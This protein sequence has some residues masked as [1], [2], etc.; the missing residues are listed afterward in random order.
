MG[1]AFVI[2]TDVYKYWQVDFQKGTIKIV[3]QNGQILEDEL[4]SKFS[5]RNSQ[6]ADSTFDWEKWW[7]ISTTT[8]GHLI[9]TEGFNPNSPPPFNGRPSVYL[10]QNRWRTV[11]DALH[12]P[13]RIADPGE[14]Q[15]AQDLIQLALDGGIVLPLSMGHMLETAG[16]HN[17]RRYEVGV[18]MGS[19]A[20]GWQIRNPLDLWK[21]EAELTIRDHLG[22]PEVGHIYP[23]VTEPGAL[24]GSDTRLG[25][26]NE[27]TD[28]DTFM[29]M[30]TMPN[31]ILSSLIDPETMPKHPL[32]MWIDHHARIT[33]RM[34]AENV[35]KSQRRQLARRRYWNENI[36][37]Y[38]APYR[39]L[40]RSF[41]FPTFSDREVA[42]LLSASPMVGLLSEL[43]VRRFTDRQNKWRRNDLI[44]I[45]HLSSAAAYA[46]YVCA[47][48]HTGTQLREAQRAL[49]RSET[50][51]TS[52]GAL[53]TAVRRDG[54]KTQ[55]ERLADFTS[56]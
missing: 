41:D 17:E 5:P 46:N 44:D 8:R 53:V 6:I 50:V 32:T 3:C 2:S 51:F 42:G 38:T 29:A 28:V 9:I 7:I 16:L 18:A 47:E 10:D 36:G 22:L 30:L 45:F 49:G 27:T 25:I 37:F 23:I 12:D 33:S 56:P 34:D 39:K 14:R 48:T 54:A 13:E 15:A 19:L 26:T 24:F 4:Q 40:T 52:L 1:E 11:A 43:F 21:Q 55:S 35:P 20:G 31:V